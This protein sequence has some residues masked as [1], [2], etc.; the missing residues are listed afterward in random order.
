VILGI[1]MIFRNLFFG[2]FWCFL[3][4][5]LSCASTQK[6]TMRA[7]EVLRIGNDFMDLQSQIRKMTIAPDSAKIRFQE[8]MIRLRQVAESQQDSICND[9]TSFVFP[10]KDYTAKS[11]GGGGS[12]YF[13][14]HYNM[15]DHS[16]QVSH[17][18]QD[19]FVRDLNRDNLDDNTLQPVDMLAMRGGIVVG[20]ES[21]WTPDSD[22]RGGN[23]VWI[24]DPCLD[25]LFYYA[26]SYRTTVVL[27][28]EVMAGEKIGE[29]GRTGL[30]ASKPRSQTHLHLMYLQL[31]AEALPKPRNTY[32]WLVGCSK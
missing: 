9:T 27:G 6:E 28:Q 32:E 14:R 26:H 8:I 15:F 5:L 21:G 16:T 11:I 13:P 22:Y 3:I 10:V 4:M 23:Y 17:A 24:Y 31:S 19:I 2:F 30:N 18:A 20:I 12:G 29:V 25:G 1:K 7:A